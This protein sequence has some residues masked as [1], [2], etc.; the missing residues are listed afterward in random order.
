MKKAIINILL[1]FF[2]GV[3]LYS[4]YRL[5]SIFSEYHEGRSEYKKTS[6]QYVKK[7]DPDEESGEESGEAGSGEAA[8]KKKKAEKAPI[9]VDFDGLLKENED[10]AGWIY[11]PDTIIDYPVMHG[12]DNDLYLHHMINKEYNFAGCIF[13]DYRNERGQKDPATILYGHNMNDGSMF[14]ALRRYTE[15]EYYDEHPTMYYLTPTQNYRLDLICCFVARDR[16]PVYSLFQTPL[17]MREYLL[18]VQDKSTFEAKKKYDLSTVNR[19]IV[20]ST[21]TN[22]ANDARYIVIGVPIPIG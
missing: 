1:V 11:C 10:V 4:G 6:N 22:D 5:F 9:E 20:L 16:D 12:K 21:C 15:Q 13:E 7:R 19:I 8:K 3:L 2:L 18:S 14:A 17:E